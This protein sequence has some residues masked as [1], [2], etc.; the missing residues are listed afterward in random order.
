MAARGLALGMWLHALLAS[1]LTFGLL[2]ALF[3]VLYAV[4]RAVEY[5]L[6]RDD[7]QGWALLSLPL[8][9]VPAVLL[10]AVQTVPFLELLGRSHRA[11]IPWTPDPI[12]VRQLI[13]LVVPNFYGN[14]S[15]TG[16]YWGGLN[17]S[18]GTLYCG[19][20]ALLLALLAPLWS[21]RFL[22]GYLALVTA[23]TLYLAA[24]GPG[25]E[26]LASM[27]PLRFAWLHRSLFLLP[28]EVPCW[29]AS[30]SATQRSELSW[31]CPRHP[32][33]EPMWCM[34]RRSSREKAKRG[35]GCWR[36]PPTWKRWPWWRLPWIC[37]PLAA[38]PRARRRSSNT[39]A[40]WSGSELPPTGPG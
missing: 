18:E 39:A 16:S 24:A 36:T 2:F 28:L 3:L 38:H 20:P 22:A 30:R 26:A 21:K 23:A 9:V 8:V 17:F 32:R 5:R 33:R 25:V 4:G 11:A 7:R 1:G 27:P 14:P 15:T 35:N 12:P 19:V 37:L 10:S 29:L 31:P 40:R 6:R 34:A 13:T